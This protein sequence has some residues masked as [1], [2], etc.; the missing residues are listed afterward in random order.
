MV[1]VKRNNENNIIDICLENKEGY[2]KSSLFTDDIKTFFKNDKDK[3]KDILNKIDIGM[4]RITEDL[5]DSL[6]KNKNILF[7]DLP[8]A[9]Q[10]KLNL[11]RIL[12]E[13]L[14][15]STNIYEEEELKL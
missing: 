11:K 1:Y 3:I 10:N 2:E 13:Q 14:N 8:D 12:R 4:V 7:T 9:V 6:I 5:I 15:F